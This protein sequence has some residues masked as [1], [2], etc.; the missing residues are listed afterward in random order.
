[1]IVDLY[2]SVLKLRITGNSLAVAKGPWLL[3]E[4]D[5]TPTQELNHRIETNILGSAM[6]N[7][8][9]EKFTDF[10]LVALGKWVGKTQNNGRRFGPD[11]GHIGILYN[12]AEKIHENRIAPAFVD[13][14]NA[15]WITQP[16]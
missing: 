1:M 15:D 6:Y 4:N 8:K 11:S 5:W 2:Q 12:L 13:L 3:G 16:Q 9:E 10:E 14:Y 7:I